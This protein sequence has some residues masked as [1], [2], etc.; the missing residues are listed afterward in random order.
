ML[1]IGLSYTSTI[2]V[3]NTNTARTYG[4]GGL[5][6]FA[7]PAMIGLME[8]AA[9]KAVE[10]QIPEGCSTVGSRIEVTHIKPSKIGAEIKATATL[11]GIEG[12]KLT[13]DVSAS[14]GNGKIGEGLHIRYIV[15]IEKFMSKLQ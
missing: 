3:D 10:D 1:S 8:N 11:V 7:T 2:L 4:S 6:V 12:R 15:D 14:D 9:M 13:F 5:D